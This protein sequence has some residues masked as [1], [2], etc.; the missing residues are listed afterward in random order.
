[1]K[2]GGLLSVRQR[3]YCEHLASGMTKGEARVAAGFPQQMRHELEPE[4]VTPEVNQYLADLMLGARQ[5]AIVDRREMLVHL[6]KVMR[7][8]LGVVD[9]GDPSIQETMVEEIVCANGTE[10]TR[11]RH[12][13]VNKLRA[14]RQLVRMQTRWKP[15]G[16]HG[17]AGGKTA[18][19]EPAMSMDQALVEALEEQAE[20]EAA[21]VPMPGTT[22]KTT[23][24]VV[25]DAGCDDDDA[26]EEATNGDDEGEESGRPSS[27]A[28][29]PP[30]PEEWDEE[31]RGSAAAGGA[32][33]M[34]VRQRLFCEYVARGLHF[35]SAYQKAG[36]AVGKGDA[37]RG[38][39]RLMTLPKVA[40]Y[41][42]ELQDEPMGPEVAELDECLVFLS[43][44]VRTPASRLADDDPLVQELWLQTRVLKD[45]TAIKRR[46]VKAVCKAGALLILEKALG[47]GEPDEDEEEALL[48]YEAE[49]EMGFEALFA[50]WAGPTLP[51]EE[52]RAMMV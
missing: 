23:M 16:G 27:L 13:L 6:T 47:L 19:D 36:Y 49:P 12:R 48:G 7:A 14:V 5:R 24:G 41:I 51:T 33:L 11:V 22:A 8:Q 35:V 21:V 26:G 28:L 31:E 9:E 32:P 46:Q 2:D 15:R 10:I 50:E 34:N 44:A 38:G 37:A 42:E 30:L 40:A 20:R 1:V 3:L 52:D 29:P 17:S 39:L 18:G 4:L 25:D 43:R 45:G